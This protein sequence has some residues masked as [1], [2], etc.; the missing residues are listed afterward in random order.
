MITRLCI[1]FGLCTGT[2]SG[3]AYVVDGDTIRIDRQS[4]RLQGVDAE[5]LS[6]PMGHA[7]R[8]VMQGIVAGKTVRCEPD[9][10][11]S[12]NRIVARCFVDGI[13]V[14]IPLIAGGWALDCPRYSHGRYRSYELPGSRDHL[15]QKGYCR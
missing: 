4:F 14:A 6:E 9:G 7:A 8:A 3:P 12:Y 13:D 15:S 11:T 1:L 5:E 10:T 2:V